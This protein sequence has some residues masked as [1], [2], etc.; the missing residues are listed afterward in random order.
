MSA[1][2]GH[3]AKSQKHEGHR[4][5]PSNERVSTMHRVCWITKQRENANKISVH[6]LERVISH[7]MCSTFTVQSRRVNDQQTWRGRKTEKNVTIKNGLQIK[8]WEEGGVIIIDS[9]IDYMSQLSV[10]SNYTLNIKIC[11]IG[12]G[13]Q[14]LY[15]PLD[16]VHKSIVR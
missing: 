15:R 5:S 14:I 2:I 3:H 4:D 7:C 12:D 1:I 11:N 13:V 8:R 6:S 16:P 10:D 9:L